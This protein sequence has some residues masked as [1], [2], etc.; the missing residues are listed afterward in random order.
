MAVASQ[1]TVATT[2]TELIRGSGTAGSD[3]VVRNTSGGA[4]VFVGGPT[5]TTA[6]GFEIPA[7]ASVGL[8]LDA[9]EALYAIVTT[10]TVR[11]D[12]LRSS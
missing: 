1:V 4:S 2:V 10:G 7:G 5:V 11:C 12:V 6:T 3:V 8:T 9:G